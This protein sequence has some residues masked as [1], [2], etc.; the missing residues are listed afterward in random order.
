[1]IRNTTVLILGSLAI[2]PTFAADKSPVTFAGQIAPIIFNNC[3]SCHRAGQAAPF[4]LISYEDV[5]KRGTLISAVTKS[6]YMPP[7][8]AAHGFGEFQDERRLTDEQIAQIDQWVK[9]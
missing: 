7:W 3:T 1:M 5:K 4:S 9:D 6:R 2:C 8:H